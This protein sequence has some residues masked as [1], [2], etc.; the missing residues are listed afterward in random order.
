MEVKAATQSLHWTIVRRTLHNI[1]KQIGVT[2][3]FEE[4]VHNLEPWEVDLLRH[5]EL[6]ADP[7]TACLELQHETGFLAGSDGS[8]K[9]GTDGAFGWMISTT[10][11]ERVACGKGP[12]RGHVMDSYRAECSGMLSILR[13]IIR[14]A[15]F[16]AAATTW[17]GT[18]GTDSQSML[19]TIFGRD[20]IFTWEKLVSLLIFYVNL[21]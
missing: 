10:G 16:T 13:F 6:F 15:E 20:R 8:E 18:I 4:F 14:L 19:D 9:F 11:G 21:E 5:T 7:Y 3:T 17:E 2:P 1:P 12:S